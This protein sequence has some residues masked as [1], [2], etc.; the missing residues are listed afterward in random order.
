MKFFFSVSVKF[1]NFDVSPANA[2]VD[3]HHETPSRPAK[4]SQA[5]RRIDIQPAEDEEGSKYFF[6]FPFSDDQKINNFFYFQTKMMDTQLSMWLTLD[7]Y[8]II[9]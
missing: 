7:S 2:D 6:Y 4:G 1:T 8:A 5:D 3:S 9:D